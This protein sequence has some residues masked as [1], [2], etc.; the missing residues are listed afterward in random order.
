MH[1]QLEGRKSILQRARCHGLITLHTDGV[2]AADRGLQACLLAQQGAKDA[3][4][5]TA[6]FG[7]ADTWKSV[8]SGQTGSSSEF[9]NPDLRKLTGSGQSPWG[10]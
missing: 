8:D 2:C 4:N 5:F 10:F 3:A 6:Q 9:N 1:W 7:R